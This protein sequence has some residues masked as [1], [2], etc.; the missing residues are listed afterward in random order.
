MRSVSFT[1]ILLCSLIL[2]CNDEAKVSEKTSKTNAGATSTNVLSPD[3]ILKT[4]PIDTIFGSDDRNPPFLNTSDTLTKFDFEKFKESL[5]ELSVSPVASIVENDDQIAFSHISWAWG[6]TGPC[7]RFILCATYIGNFEITFSDGNI[8][9][10]RIIQRLTTS[11]HD[12]IAN[13]KKAL[14]GP[15]RDGVNPD[16]GLA[17]GWVMASQIHN[18][19]VYDWLRNHGDAV[20]RALGRIR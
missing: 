2:S 11:A 16:R 20:I 1:S 4:P 18:R 19:P 10:N 7:T 3:G 13:A 9:F 17:V 5:S 12:C 6:N 14:R 8:G 15:N